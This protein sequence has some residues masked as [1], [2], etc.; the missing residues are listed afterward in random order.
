MDAPVLIESIPAQVI[1][2]QSAYGPFDLKAFIKAPEGSDLPTFQAELKDGQALPKGMICTS[3]GMITGI[4]AKGTQGNYEVI[5]TATNQAGST[6]ASFIMSITPSFAS[7]E[8]ETD[9]VNQLKAQVWEALDQRLP[10]PDLAELYEREISP[11]EIYYLLERWGIIKI[12][13]AFNLEPPKG[14]VLLTLDGASQHYNVYDGGSCLVATPVD[15]FSYERTLEDG[16]QTARAMAREVYN[17]GWT[18]EL[19]GFEKFV[20][21]A[22]VEIQHL[23]DKYGKHLEVINFSPTTHD[24]K[25]YSM[26]AFTKSGM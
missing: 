11:L 12:W 18:I 22:W 26:E 13:D 17:R 25:I 23:G 4:P 20:R 5:V 3:D 24:V 15:L 19:V 2:E 1:N 6:Q 10:I 16:L 14:K 9:Y 7:R 21:A 8:T